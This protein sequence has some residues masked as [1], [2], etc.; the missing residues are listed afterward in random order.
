M[1]GI[2]VKFVGSVEREVGARLGLMEKHSKTHLRD[3]LS[4]EQRILAPHLRSP[5]VWCKSVGVRVGA[6]RETVG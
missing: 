4:K 1:R 6:E 2:V 3:E 5:E